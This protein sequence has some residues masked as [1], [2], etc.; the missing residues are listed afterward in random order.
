MTRRD[1][2]KCNLNWKISVGISISRHRD[3]DQLNFGCRDYEKRNLNRRISVRILI[4]CRDYDDRN[5]EQKVKR[6]KNTHHSSQISQ[7]TLREAPLKFMQQAFGLL[8]LPPHSNGHSGAL[9]LRKIAPNHPGKGLNPPP[10]TGNAQIKSR[11][12]KW[13]FP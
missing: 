11:Q 2:E 6:L 9:C 1:Y 3:Y 4:S 13:G 8:H 10:L 12:T 5:I 7:T